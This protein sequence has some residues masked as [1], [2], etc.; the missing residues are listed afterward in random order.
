MKT[1][2][3]GAGITGLYLAFKL[4]GKGEEVTV[5][6]KRGEIGKKACSGLFSQRILKFI[7]Q[8]EALIENEI[9]SAL[10]HFPKRTLRINF[11]KRFFVMNHSGL[12]NLL[13]GLA[14]EAGA[15]IFLNQEVSS[16]PEG[17]DRVIGCDGA[18]S[19]VRRKLGLKEPYFRL[20]I[21]GFIV[22]EDRS[23]FVETWPVRNGF[24]WKIPRA[25]KLNTA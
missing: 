12:D 11:S 16:M 4:A 20:A 24:I 18:N 19:I 13:A 14:K 21:Q 6:E 5:F 1:A 22:K 9:D 2:I 25:K 23:D 17:F 8:S 3:V 10:I 15:K 7:P